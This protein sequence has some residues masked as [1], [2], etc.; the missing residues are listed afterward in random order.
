MISSRM[1]ISRSWRS[2]HPKGMLKNQQLLNEV[3]A[4]TYYIMVYT[5]PRNQ[6]KYVLYLVLVQKIMVYQSTKNC[7]LDQT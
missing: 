2:W 7:Y 6:G 5:I 3:I 4:D 1:I